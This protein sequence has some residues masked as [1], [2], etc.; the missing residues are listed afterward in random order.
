MP[1]VQDSAHCRPLIPIALLLQ[2]EGSTQV[3]VASAQPALRSLSPAPSPNTPNM[4][5]YGLSR[6]AS[7]PVACVQ[8]TMPRALP[9]ALAWQA[10]GVGVRRRRQ[11]AAASA[12][13][14]QQQQQHQQQQQQQVSLHLHADDP[15]SSGSSGPLAAPSPTHLLAAAALPLAL[16]AAG[17]GPA[18]A[19]EVFQ[20][21][22]NAL[23][24]PTWMVHTSSVLEWIVAM[25]LM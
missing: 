4:Q 25:G 6:P 22:A 12:A 24:L 19:L 20:E 10:A 23:S 1:G 7:A 17:A 18:A 16:L 2:L 13:G 3:A 14:P 11:A 15:S 9:T 8:A 5:L 21:P